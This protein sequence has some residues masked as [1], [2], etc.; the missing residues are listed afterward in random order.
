MRVLERQE[1]N[2]SE[3]MATREND[4]CLQDHMNHHGKITQ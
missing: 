2:V 1:F 3:K 4:Q